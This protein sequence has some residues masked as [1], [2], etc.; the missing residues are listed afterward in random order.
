V[1]SKSYVA[2]LCIIKMNNND[3]DDDD[4]DDNNNNNNN[5]NV[6][7]A[8]KDKTLLLNFINSKQC[9]EIISK[10]RSSSSS[11]SSSS[12]KQGLGKTACSDFIFFH[13]VY[14]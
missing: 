9:I 2:P 14:E 12:S 7:M 10:M 1:G 8:F 11:S 3:D 13:E 5:N 6:K 4:D